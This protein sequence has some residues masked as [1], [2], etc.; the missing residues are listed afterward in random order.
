MQNRK[1]AGLGKVASLVAIVAL[2]LPTV[3]SA[4]ND[5][6]RSPL[7]QAAGALAGETFMTTCGAINTLAE[8]WQT[9]SFDAGEAAK[10]A[11]S[12]RQTAELTLTLIEQKKHSN[13]QKMMLNA[14]KA[15]VGQAQALEIWIDQNNEPTMQ[16]Y[17]QFAARTDL[18]VLAITGRPLL[19][20]NL[21]E[22]RSFEF[23]I[24]GS[25]TASGQDGPLGQF[26]VFQAPREQRV[27]MR[28]K[29]QDCTAEMGIGMVFPGTKFV[30]VSF[31]RS[32]GQ[33][34][35]YR[36]DAEGLK[37]SYVSD[38][39]GYEV[40]SAIYP[41]SEVDGEYLWSDGARVVVTPRGDGFADIVWR[42]A[43]GSESV[44][45][46][47]I[48]EGD[49]IAAVMT[50]PDERFGVGL[51]ALSQDGNGAGRWLT[52]DGRSGTEKLLVRASA[53]PEP[54]EP[55]PPAVALDAEVRHFAEL[56]RENLGNVAAYRPDDSQIEAI[57]ATAE[58]A[59]KLRAYVEQVYA[60]IPSSGSAAKQGQTEIITR[61]PELRDL[62]GGYSQQI[63]H[64]REG[65]RI[66]SFKY[67]EPGKTS[68][69]AYDGLI[70]I[71]NKW[72]F[73]PKAWRAFAQ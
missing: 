62:P 50:R 1:R 49:M 37:G 11:E 35:V 47:A 26:T 70:P 48:M 61:G 52:S 55:T 4:K 41:R 30:G 72:V 59:M 71:G 8:T 3:A 17:L 45:A 19:S 6:L 34:H 65:I 16:Q 69:M 43:D 53:T 57:A 40:K 10:L 46:I 28:W 33:L 66:Y 64:F 12:Y 14:G 22:T 25:E 18:A 15:L 68:G 54:A 63:G 7:L 38:M 58:D 2:A 29:L 56:L 5:A 20:I 23:D 42:R 73:I 31:G 24:V 67:V 32:R 51:Y 60:Q 13:E 9:G 39:P 21:N 36:M 44:R 27:G